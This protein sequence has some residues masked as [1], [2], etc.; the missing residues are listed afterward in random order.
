MTGLEIAAL[1][2]SI[3]GAGVS[4]ASAA[5]IP[6]DTDMQSFMGRGPSDPNYYY[7]DP[8]GLLQT[9][10]R[11]ARQM[12]MGLADIAK[13]P[14]TM[15]SGF[16]QPL[17]TFTG[18]GLPM[19]IGIRAFDPALSNPG[20]LTGPGTDVTRSPDAFGGKP[21]ADLFPSFGAADEGYGR[22]G[23]GDTGEQALSSLAM[24]GLGEAGGP[25]YKGKFGKGRA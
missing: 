4:A 6:D 9:G 11:G 23:Y 5:S 13:Q 16:A 21:S 20:L 25:G 22:E 3:A 24:L 19:P 18:G 14:I 1:I 8:R 10:G 15:R 17:P 2:S 12:G 7:S